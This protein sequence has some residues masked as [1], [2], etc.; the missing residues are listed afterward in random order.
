MKK[1]GRIKRIV[2]TVVLLAGAALA[3]LLMFGGEGFRW[4]GERSGDVG[5]SIRESSEEL[6]ERADE[7]REDLGDKAEK[8]KE[9]V[10]KKVK[11]E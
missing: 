4:F 2:F 7:L 10:K 11:G 8:L 5:E 1:R 9:D 3:V 6:G